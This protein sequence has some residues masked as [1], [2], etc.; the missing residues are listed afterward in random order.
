MR[1]IRIEV[2][3]RE[4]SA[5]ENLIEALSPTRLTLAP[6]EL[7][8]VLVAE[9]EDDAP[10][11]LEDRLEAWLNGL[12]CD[13]VAIVQTARD[14][15]EWQDGWR[16]IYRGII[17]ERFHIHPPWV[18]PMGGMLDVVLNPR[19]GFGGGRHPATQLALQ[20]LSDLGGPTG[21]GRLL[22]VGSGTGV[23]AIAA[24]RLG[25]AVVAIEREP[26]A[27]RL[28]RQNVQLNG[29]CI[30]VPED[31]IDHIA[32]R[33]DVV[34]A[35]LYG[36]TGI[37]EIAGSLEKVVAGDGRLFVGGFES[38]CRENILDGFS[39]LGLELHC[40]SQLEGFMGLLLSCNHSS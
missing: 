9:F 28:C 33:F 39:R 22:D 36:A 5:L 35:N 16:G 13:E 37:L 30:D 3:H 32:D 38:S 15:A 11:Y 26:L 1:R 4:A 23:L 8:T 18:E 29:L 34:L 12:R 21:H 20:T 40:E 27:R 7:E 10:P 2:G 24:A 31:Q 17:V 6:A 25:W 14:N 19:G